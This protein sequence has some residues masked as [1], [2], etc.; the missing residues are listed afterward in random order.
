MHTLD[1]LKGIIP[2][3]L[4]TARSENLVGWQPVGIKHRFEVTF[5]IFFNLI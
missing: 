1:Y 4:R 5:Y 3:M 2:K